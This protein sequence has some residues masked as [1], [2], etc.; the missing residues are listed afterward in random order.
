MKGCHKWNW[1]DSK[2]KTKM[3]WTTPGCRL[4][5]PKRDRDPRLWVKPLMGDWDKCDQLIEKKDLNELEGKGYA[6]DDTLS[7]GMPQMNLKEGH[8]KQT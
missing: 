4:W 7:K 5:M 1:N 8:S 2:L 3:W 6:L